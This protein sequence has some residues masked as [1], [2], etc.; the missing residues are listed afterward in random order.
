[1]DGSV[2]IVQRQTLD[3]ET[4][5]LSEFERQSKSFCRLWGKPD[6]YIFNIVTLWSNTFGFSYF[7]VRAALKKIAL[8]SIEKADGVVFV[9]YADY[10]NIPRL[11]LPYIFID[12]DDWV[13]PEISQT[14]D[15]V[16]LP[17]DALLWRTV[18]VGSPNQEYPVFVWG[19]NGRC[20]T[21]NYAVNGN[22]LGDQY[23]LADVI[24]HSNAVE[25]L[26]ALESV[27]ELDVA[28]TATNKSP[29]SSVSLDRGLNGCLESRELVKLIDN[30]LEKMSNLAKEHM[31]I[32]PWIKSYV[33]ET[34]EVFKQVQVSQR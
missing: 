26:K 13:S 17:Y 16:V 9:P 5:S 4:M 12:D 23:Q 33:D 6:D 20:M 19:L 28:L 8:C 22:L 3:W 29:C 27:I 11:N 18:S 2:V 25:T 30:F 7:Q 24:Q 34:V 31:N 14:L 10:Q 1:M 32:A 15:N 21:N